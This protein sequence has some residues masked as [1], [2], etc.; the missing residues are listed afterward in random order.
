GDREVMSRSSPPLVLGLSLALLIGIILGVAL[1]R[2]GPYL[3]AQATSTTPAA[4]PEAGPPP[5]T[6]RPAAPGGPARSGSDDEVYRQL[7]QQYEQFR[8]INQTFELVARAVAPSV[9]HI[10]AHKT[11]RAEE[12]SRIRH[13]EETGSGVIVRGDRG[14]SLYVLT[15]NH[16]I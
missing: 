15:N 5:A 8:Q 6:V 10:V 12:S 9:V 2:G 13:F 4:R 11:S 16:V 7:D 1:D 3:S 14:R